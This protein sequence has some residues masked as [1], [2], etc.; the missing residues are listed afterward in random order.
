MAWI[1]RA[2]PVRQGQGLDS[3]RWKPWNNLKGW[4]GLNHENFGGAKIL[5]VQAPLFPMVQAW[6]RPCH[7]FFP[8]APALAVQA[9]P[10]AHRSS[11]LD[12]SH[13][14]NPFQ[15]NPSNQIQSNQSN[16]IHP[17]QNPIFQ[18]AIFWARGPR[19]PRAPN[20]FVLCCFFFKF[21]PMAQGAQGPKVV[22]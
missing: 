8:W 2:G 6:F 4:W 9:L 20:Q 18:F 15:S 1:Q 11:P 7:P 5:M 21:G 13:S 12:P 3:K 22:L 10:L 19:G 16:P 17:N 14:S